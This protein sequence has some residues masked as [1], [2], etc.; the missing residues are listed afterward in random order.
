MLEILR[1]QDFGFYEGKKTFER[2]RDGSGKSGR[3]AHADAHRNDPGFQDFESKASMRMRMDKFV[4]GYL[5][6]S[7]VQLDHTVVIVAHG[8]IL[9][10]L[11]RVILK[12]LKPENITVAQGIQLPERGSSPS[13][14]NT[15]YMD[16][17]IAPT[18]NFS[19][20]QFC[21]SPQPAPNVAEEAQGNT[22]DAGRSLPALEVLLP[23][24]TAAASDKPPIN[25]VGV[26]EGKLAQPFKFLNMSLVVKALN[27]REHL[28]GLKKS[29]G[30]LG[31]LKHDSSQKTL[32][33]FFKKRRLE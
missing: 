10:Y 30:G 22:L 4:D 11:W 5:L 31:S 18:N 23:Q 15:G 3:E 20:N 1:E 26:A 9:I 25:S 14:S 2:P 16:L 32:D 19:L 6:D 21:P 27:N 28:N 29:G 7:K 33:S 17:E 8:I 13:W 12:R 24:S